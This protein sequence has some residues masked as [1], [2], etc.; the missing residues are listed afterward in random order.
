MDKTL[1]KKAMEM[2]PNERVAFA[3]LI[4]QS[5]DYEEDEIRE[6]WINEVRDRMDAVNKGTSHLIDFEARY[7]E[8]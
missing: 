6:A 7:I 8:S 3:E 1:F 5:I 2:P 4:L